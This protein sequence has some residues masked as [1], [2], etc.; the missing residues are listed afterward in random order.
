MCGLYYCRHACLPYKIC[1][2]VCPKIC[3]C[4][5]LPFTSNLGG[6]GVKSVLHHSSTKPHTSY[7]FTWYTRVYYIT[8]ERRYRP[9]TISSVHGVWHPP[10][11]IGGKFMYICLTYLWVNKYYILVLKEENDASHEKIFVCVLQI[12]DSVM[13]TLRNYCRGKQQPLWKTYFHLNRNDTVVKNI[14]YIFPFWQEMT[15]S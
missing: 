11:M 12:N 10:H 4:I 15:W 3:L 13:K 14:S 2:Y 7:M 5:A 9:I 6:G 8:P 1:M